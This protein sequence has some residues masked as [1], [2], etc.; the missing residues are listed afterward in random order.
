[1]S[2]MAFAHLSLLVLGGVLAAI[3]IILHLTMRR[4]PKSVTFPAVRFLVQ[5]RETN[6]RSLNL[7]HWVLLA[8]RILVLILL[9]LAFARPS[10]AS[11]VFG[12][13]L[14]A[15]ALGIGALVIAALLIGAVVQKRGGLIIAAFI[16]V[17]LL[18]VGGGLHRVILALQKGPKI[19]LGGGL[20][21]VSAV[22]VFDD[23]P[24]MLL[25]AANKTRLQAAQELASELLGQL[26]PDSEA[27]ILSTRV[28]EVGA[29]NKVMAGFV[30][31]LALA[32]RQVS[33]I[34]CRPASTLPLD[35]IEEGLALLKD[36]KKDRKEVYIFTD[37]TAVSWPA[38]SVAAIRAAADKA[39][40]VGFFV[41]D[42]GLENPANLALENLVLS[43]ETP[44][45][46]TDLSLEVDLKNQGPAAKRQL[47]LDIEERDPKRWPILKDGKLE[48]PPS[49]I[50]GQQTIDLPENGSRSAKFQLVGS[51]PGVYHGRIRFEQPDALTIDDEITFTYQ[52]RALDNYLIVAPPD[53]APSLLDDAVSLRY[54]G[55]IITPDKIDTLDLSAYS[56]ICLLDPPPIPELSWQK[57]ESYVEAGGGLA[58]YLGHSCETTDAKL[59]PRFINPTVERLL[60]AIPTRVAR[61]PDDVY[62]TPLNYE[63]AIL[64]PLRSVSTSV[65]WDRMPIYYYWLMSA[66]AESGSII[67]RTSGG[68]PLYLERRVAGPDGKTGVVLL[69]ATPISDPLSP[70][71]R[72]TW[73]EIPTGEDAWPFV[74]LAN[75]SL[76]YLCAARRDKFNYAPGL[77]VTLQ[78]DEK[79]YP[80][81]YQLF[82]PRGSATEISAR[83]G[84]VSVSTTNELGVFRLKGTRGGPQT[85]GFSI[86]LPNGATDLTRCAPALL[87]EAFGKNRYQVARN[88]SEIEHSL[89]SAR[90]GRDFYPMLVSLLAIVFALENLLANRFYKGATR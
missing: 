35:L 55:A 69:M 25:K 83:N 71:G 13:W 37:L 18:L 54:T 1:M 56:S 30:P 50:R 29:K 47:R 79:V 27:A 45:I 82:T 66:P 49:E 14:L 63:H 16:I 88:V 58:V 9:A 48:P 8:L 84:V 33:A 59:D 39:E 73:N 44:A 42:V 4:R 87:E 51:G 90:K 46:G 70:K 10:V 31:D 43:S 64:R 75:E 22:F 86:R 89:T 28:K 23:S 34:E 65:P 78:N 38:E 41:I 7:R 60:P 68:D 40:Q 5:K 21:P 24:R 32:A 53:V 72:P 19:L 17:L 11:A 36:S 26:P 74:V 12:D 76:D 80:D 3:P 81:K 20:A 52:V 77:L 61:A 15:G 6:Q 62:A 57:L 2:L 85:R 67:L